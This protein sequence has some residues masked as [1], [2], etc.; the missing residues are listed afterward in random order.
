MKIIK[1][2]FTYF[3]SIIIE[4]IYYNY[5]GTHGHTQTHIYRTTF[6]KIK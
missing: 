3:Y 5:I 1:I 4:K 2:N 6:N